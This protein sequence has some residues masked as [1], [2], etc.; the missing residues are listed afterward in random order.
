ML[1]FLCLRRALLLLVLL[2]AP[3]DANRVRG[4]DVRAARRETRT[5]V[6]PGGNFTMGVDDDER[7]RFTEACKAEVFDE[8]K[9]LLCDDASVIFTSLLP[10]ARRVYVSTF[11]IDRYEVTTRQ[12][13]AC[14]SAKACDPRPLVVG[15]ARF[16]RDEWPV[17]N[18]TF[19]EAEAYCRWRGMR[20]PTEAE[21]EKAARGADVEVVAKTGE[22]SIVPRRWPWGPGWRPDGANLGAFAP[23]IEWPPGPTQQ[24]R[25]QTTTDARDGTESLAVPGAH[26]WGR[27]PYGVADLS[28]NVS[29]WVLDWFSEQGYE[30]LSSIDPVRSGHQVRQFRV[31]RGG[32]FQTPRMWGRTYMRSADEEDSR[33]SDR[34]FRCARSIR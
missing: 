21:W 5:A 22:K 24:L 28:G 19:D 16:V 9:E 27:S 17:V 25:W 11:E 26:K 30:G 13:R 29:E 20:L 14:V 3:A 1:R 8:L 7:E 4:E 18:V 15:D 34:G 32:S 12:F 6:V 10:E 23:K 31:V 2:A 33:R